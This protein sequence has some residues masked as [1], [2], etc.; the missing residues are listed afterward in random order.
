MSY[1]CLCIYLFY[2]AAENEPRDLLQ[3]Q[4]TRKMVCDELDRPRAGQGR[5]KM[6]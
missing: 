2:C 6:A 3:E 5:M 1:I 4:V